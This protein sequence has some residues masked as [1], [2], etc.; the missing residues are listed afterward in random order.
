VVAVAGDSPR[1]P[2]I[3]I[4][5]ERIALAYAPGARF[6]APNYSPHRTA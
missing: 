4:F 2:E 1:L 3:L 6:A 5:P